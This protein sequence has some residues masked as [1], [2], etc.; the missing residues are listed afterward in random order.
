MKSKDWGL[1]KFIH[2]KPKHRILVPGYIFLLELRSIC[3]HW[4]MRCLVYKWPTSVQAPYL[5]SPHFISTIKHIAYPTQGLGDLGMCSSRGRSCLT[6]QSIHLV[7]RTI[8]YFRDS[9]EP[10][11]ITFVH[12]TVMRLQL[13]LRDMATD[14]QNWVTWGVWMSQSRDRSMVRSTNSPSSLSWKYIKEKNG[15]KQIDGGRRGY[16]YCAHLS[17]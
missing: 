8:V 13:W 15:V 17:Y 5:I 14:R 3:I 6:N 4:S 10:T 11:P 1:R 16:F 7:D 12:P 2:G 9:S